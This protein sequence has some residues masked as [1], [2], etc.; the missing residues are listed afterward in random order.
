MLVRSEKQAFENWEDYRDSL[1]KETF[2][3]LNET[4][5][6]KAKR[7][8][9]LKND[10]EKFCKYYFPNYCK[11]EFAPFQLRFAERIIK[12]KVIYISREWARA[13]AKSVLADVL[14][15][16][17]LKFTGEMKNMLLVSHNE[18]NAIEL[19]K[20]LQIQFESNARLINDFGKQHGF[21]R[22]E[23]GNFVTKDGC[24][25]RAIGTGQSPRGARNEE[26]RPDY[27]AVDDA[28]EDEMCRNP[29]RLDNNWDWMQGALFG[30]FDIT[31]NK[32]FVVIGNVIAKDSLVV[33]ASAVSDDTERINI[34]CKGKEIDKKLIRELQNKLNE[35]NEEK[36]K[37]VYVEAIGFL[38]NG[39]VP[40]WSRFTII[41]CAYMITKMGYRNSQK[42]YFNNPISEGKVFKKA[43]MQYK[44]LPPLTAYRFLLAYLDPGFKKTATSDSKALVLVGLHEGQFHIRKIYCG[45]AS[46]E[47]MIEWGYS[48]DT[49]VKSQNAVYQFKMEEVFLQS[50][51]YKDFSAAAKTKKYSLPVSGDTRKK[52]DKD[53]RIESISG[54][55]ER[56]DVW[57]SEELEKEHH[58]I[59]AVEQLLNFEPG[60]KTKK[61]FPDALEGAFHLLQQNV[62]LNAEIFIG[63]RKKNHHK[64]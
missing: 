40:S 35:I 7:I 29:K 14:I 44:K 32:R 34:F 4:S 59:A 37:Q 33:R 25:F 53:Q 23:D 12:K 6:D 10:F 47:E 2:I 1:V 38:K 15:P 52:P 19:L 58:A 49:F 20:P 62:S 39:Y 48:M 18:T 26:A 24:S 51:L 30:C 56:G 43:W 31:G 8:S 57:F 42:E 22:W 9:E 27:I 3:D 36:E 55:F 17:Y 21:G 28:D 63:Q 45:Q 61:D 11:S 60:V 16:M 54:Y 5:A 64:I 13:H 50:L 46:V 41:D